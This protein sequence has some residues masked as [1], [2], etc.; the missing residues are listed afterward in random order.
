MFCSEVFRLL[1]VNVF[2]LGAFFIFDVVYVMTILI[3]DGGRS[4]ETLL[5]DDVIKSFEEGAISWLLFYSIICSFDLVMIAED[6][7]VDALI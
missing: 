2:G 1:N 3:S 6:A 7:E 4:G 5:L